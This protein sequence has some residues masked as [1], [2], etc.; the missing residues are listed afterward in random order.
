MSQT[1][2]AFLQQKAAFAPQQGFDI[3]LDEINPVL[4]PFQ[5]MA[6]QWAVRGGRRALFERFGLGKTLQ[7]LEI[8][9]LVLVKSWGTKGLIVCPLGVKQEFAT[10]AARLGLIIRFVRTDLEID[11]LCLPGTEP[12][13]FITNY[14]SVREG[15]IDPRRFDVISLDEAAILR[16]FGG[17][18]TFRAFM[19][20]FEGTATYRFVATATPSPNEYIELLAYAAFLGVMDVSEAKTRFF[21][22]NSEKAATLTLLPS[23]EQEFWLWVASW[24]LFLQKPSDLGPE[25][26]DEGYDLPP[27]EVVWHEVLSDYDATVPNRDGQGRLFPNSA[28]GV[29]D[30]AREKRSSLEARTDLMIELLTDAPGEHCVL[31]H[32]LEAERHAI[33]AAVPDV[34]TVYGSQDLDTRERAI[35]DFRDGK[36][37]YIAGKPVML[38]A[39][40]NWQRHCHWAIFLGIGFKFA[41]FI[42]AIHRIHRFLQEKPVRIDLIYTEAEQEI[43]RTLERKWAQYEVQVREMTGIIREYGLVQA[44][45][46]YA[47]RRGI[48]VERLEVQTS[49]YQLVRADAIEEAATMPDDSVHLILTSIP[50]STQYEYSP[51][52]NDFGHNED[53][54]QFWAQMA[55]LSPHL[56]RTLK[57]GRIM[58]IHVKDRI[59]PGGING[60][61]FQT[62]Y[63]FHCD[64]ITHYTSHGFAYL[65]MKTIV[66]DVV[67]ENNQ[68]YRLG[69]SEQCKDGSRMGVGMPEYLLIFRKPPTDLSNGYADEPVIKAKSD[70][71]TPNG[72][73]IPYDYDAGKMVPGTGYSRA[74]WQIDAHGFERSSGNR[75]L[76]EEELM[77]LPHAALYKR[78]RE[79]SLSTIYDHERHVWLGEVMER[80]KRLPANFML[81]PPHSWHPD[82]WAD[83]ARMRNL[84]MT[85]AS[86]GRELHLCPMQEDICQRVIRQFSMPDEVVFDPFVGL[87]SVVY[88]AVKMGRRG[89]GHELSAN[90]FADAVTYCRAAEQEMPLP[91]LFG[92]LEDLDHG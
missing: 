15:K 59:V 40:V 45:M 38:G 73:V 42:Q 52:M 50:F 36:I 46:A 28:I 56:Y 3:D 32:D 22:R 31:W 43:R 7:Q 49:R 29:Q 80:E 83:V 11:N 60:L 76:T 1:Y 27:L 84:N 26:S 39:G 58:V 71:C 19:G 78:W 16:G 67:R 24:A 30:A 41:D 55:Y 63:P 87:G 57:P 70:T 5:R 44:S 10:D 25:Y 86:K 6:V 69:W 47:L 48:G 37:P 74:R 66:T 2:Q 77:Q 75:L 9:R 17:T 23:K 65:G 8:L 13:L 89:I 14:E 64:A 72:E 62:V 35:I 68:T 54:A 33:E 82:V 88:W 91:G 53:N 79:E 81:M 85:Q 90:Y 12:Q 4:F 51:S 20:L 21:K 34:V 92:A 61:G 18:K